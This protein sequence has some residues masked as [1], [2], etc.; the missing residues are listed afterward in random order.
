MSEV[1]E[2]EQLINSGNPTPLYNVVR[3]WIYSEYAVDGSAQP[4]RKLD[5]IKD[6]R[7]PNLGL[8]G[9]FVMRSG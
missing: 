4:W 6:G 5:D 1:Q 7:L 8:A 2:Y 9:P 3:E